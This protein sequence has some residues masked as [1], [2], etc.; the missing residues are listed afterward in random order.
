MLDLLLD[1]NVSP[2]FNV[3]DLFPFQGTFEPL[4]LSTGTRAGST[5]LCRRET[6]LPHTLPP[7]VDHIETVLED[8]VIFAPEGVTSRYLVK[9]KD[10][11]IIDATWIFED[12][13]CHLD[14]Y[15]LKQY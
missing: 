8:Q 7:V 11:P 10:R 13:F 1:L 5:T 9:W 12:E 6:V 15:L 2:T 4:S 3:E 14:A